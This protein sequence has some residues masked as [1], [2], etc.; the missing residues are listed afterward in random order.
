MWHVLTSPWY[1]Y[2]WAPVR[3]PAYR[4][5]LPREWY[6]LP[7]GLR[8]AGYATSMAGKWHLTTGADGD[9][10][11]LNPTA[12]AAYGF[13]RVAP[14]GPGLPNE[15]DKL[16]DSLTD[17]AIDFIRSNRDHPWFFYLAHHTLHGVQLEVSVGE[18][19]FEPSILVLQLLQP[20]GLRDFQP[21]VLLSPSVET[22]LADTVDPADFL[23]CCSSS[24]QHL[25]DLLVLPLPA[26]Q[27]ILLG[28]RFLP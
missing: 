5:S 3:E 13:D 6:T 7:K 10:G 1:G 19:L 17:S 26:S 21:F 12:G 22:G 16:V 27:G 20:T 24:L 23:D 2:P 9:Y 18:D 25:D 8:G 11:S 14:R 4:E 15:G 28:R